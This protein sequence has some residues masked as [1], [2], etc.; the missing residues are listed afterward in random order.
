MSFVASNMGAHGPLTAAS[1]MDISSAK[2]AD[3][4]SCIA[5]QYEGYFSCQHKAV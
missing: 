3:R 4:L 5:Q 2:A 1:A